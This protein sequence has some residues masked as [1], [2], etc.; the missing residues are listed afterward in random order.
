MNNTCYELT[1]ISYLL[2]YLKINKE[3]S[4]V[5]FYE[6]RV[7]TY[8]IKNLVFYEIT[9]QIEM[10]FQSIYGKI[11]DRSIIIKHVWK[12]PKVENIFTIVGIP[13]PTP[14][15][16]PYGSRKYLFSI[17][18]RGVEISKP[19]SKEEETMSEEIDNPQRKG[20][21]VDQPRKMCMYIYV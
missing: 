11:Q 6:K 7:I 16:C 20:P 5:I 2:N 3:E 18:Q 15:Y 19:E 1:W 4:I 10:D 21:R 9:R 14:T 13:I 17:L 12:Y 8:V